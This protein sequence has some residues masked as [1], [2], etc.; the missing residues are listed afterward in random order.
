MNDPKGNTARLTD[1]F[2]SKKYLLGLFRML[3]FISGNRFAVMNAGMTSGL[4]F[5]WEDWQ[6][7]ASQRIHHPAVFSGS[8]R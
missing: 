7:L 1:V 6:I 8:Q 2:L 3:W 5:Q 4:S